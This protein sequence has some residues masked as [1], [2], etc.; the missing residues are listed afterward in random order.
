MNRRMMDRQKDGQINACCVGMYTN[1]TNKG[2]RSSLSQA[3]IEVSNLVLSTDMHQ[4][5]TLLHPKTCAERQVPQTH[6][7]GTEAGHKSVNA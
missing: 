5:Y 6:W 2:S 3:L 7:Q 4:H 1:N